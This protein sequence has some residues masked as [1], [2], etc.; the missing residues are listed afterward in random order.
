MAPLLQV[1]LDAG[2]ADEVAALASALAG[3]VDRVEVGTPL[4]L[5]H[6]LGLVRRIAW[7]HPGL[8]L[9]ADA[10]IVDAAEHEA[11]LALA[12]GATWVTTLAAVGPTPTEGASRAAAR[13]GGRVMVD[14]LGVT[15]L[16]DAARAGLA[17]GADLVA[18]H[19]GVDAQAVGRTPLADLALL[20]AELPHAPLAVAGGITLDTLP[21]HLALRP[22]V[23]IVGSAVTA[24]ADPV[25][26]AR[27]FADAVRAGARA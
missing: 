17:A 25:G 10:K 3:I 20:R 4:L 1:A 18:V 14:L 27:A 11:D 15:D 7:L 16:P 12:A 5:H 22:D 21:D 9:L 24:A 23:V 2:E 6:G 19:T 13:R 8:D 26:A